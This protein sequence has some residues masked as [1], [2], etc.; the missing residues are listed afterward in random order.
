MQIEAEKLSLRKHIVFRICNP[1]VN[2]VNFF[3]FTLSD[4]KNKNR[5]LLIDNP[6]KIVW[7]R[8]NLFYTSGNY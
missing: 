5:F 8:L 1:I 2:N 6:G 7:N 4:I 3:F